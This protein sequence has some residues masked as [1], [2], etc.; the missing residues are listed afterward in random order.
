MNCWPR[1]KK[2]GLGSAQVAD[3]LTTEP[4]WCPLARRGIKKT[5]F[6]VM[7]PGFTAG[8]PGALEEVD[9]RPVLHTCSRLEPFHYVH[10]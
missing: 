2:P 1:P 6:D 3:A 5:R 4:R 10:A 9:Q 8:L 7:Y